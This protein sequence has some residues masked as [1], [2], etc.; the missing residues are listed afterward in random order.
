M[1]AADL[2]AISARGSGWRAA[3]N[4]YRDGALATARQR[5]GSA[6]AGRRRDRS[7]AA[8]PVQPIRFDNADGIA[9]Y[10]ALRGT[11]RSGYRTLVTSDD[12]APLLAGEAVELARSLA[13]TGAQVMLVDWTFR[14]ATASSV[15]GLKRTPGMADLVGGSATFETAVQ[16]DRSST[17]QVIAGGIEAPALDDELADNLRLVLEALDEAY[18]HI[19]VVA[20]RDGAELLLE[21]LDGRFDAGVLLT[22]SGGHGPAPAA[23]FIGFE[24]PGLDL[25]R[26]EKR[27]DTGAPGL[28]RAAPARHSVRE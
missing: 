17:L 24:V 9:R 25:I 18:Q 22:D 1:P 5:S 6:D 3:A 2:P 28:R 21:T 15:V 14:G 4:A 27:V 20:D 13:A 26:L 16:R 8:G 11:S 7:P 19:V 12:A 10:L 23:G